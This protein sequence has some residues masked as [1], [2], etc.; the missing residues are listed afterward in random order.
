[1]SALPKVEVWTDGSCSP[2]PG[3]GGWAAI[4]LFRKTNGEIVRRE[5][6]AGTEQTTNNRME[7]TGVLMGLRALTRRCHVTAVVRLPVAQRSPER[8]GM[9]PGHKR[10]PG[11][12]YVS[13]SLPRIRQSPS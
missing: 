2:N 13:L 9:L 10:L 1:M 12:V 6:W 7:M 3:P 4:L 8:Y 11:G 5:L